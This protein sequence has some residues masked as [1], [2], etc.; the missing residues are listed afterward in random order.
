MTSREGTLYSQ[1]ESHPLE[2][3]LRH[4]SIPTGNKHYGKVIQFQLFSHEISSCNDHYLTVK[5]PF[6]A[7]D[8]VTTMPFRARSRDN[9]SYDTGCA[10]YILA[11]DQFLLDSRHKQTQ[12]QR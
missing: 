4:S 5:T 8:A 2:H 6:H 12:T 9:D 3:S 7:R 1:L 10:K 11:C